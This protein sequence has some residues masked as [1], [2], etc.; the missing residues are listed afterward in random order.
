MLQKEG[1]EYYNARGSLLDRNTVK[2][3]QASGKVSGRWGLPWSVV[4]HCNLHRDALS[5]NRAKGE[6]CGCVGRH[7][8]NV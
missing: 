7:T 2:A 5:D 8:P 1:V 4:G 3:V 6:A